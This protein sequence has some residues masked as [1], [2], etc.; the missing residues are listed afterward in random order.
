MTDIIIATIEVNERMY[1]ILHSF[2]CF[3]TRVTIEV[4]ECKKFMTYLSI[5]EIML[6][7]HFRLIEV[8]FL[9]SSVRH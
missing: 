2:D 4:K 9:H 7:F 1:N 3:T 6:R 8:F 5:F